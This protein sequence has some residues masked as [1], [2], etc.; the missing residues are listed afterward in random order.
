[1]SFRRA[2]GASASRLLLFQQPA[3]PAPSLSPFFAPLLLQTQPEMPKRFALSSFA[4][5]LTRHPCAKS[6]HCHFYATM[7]GGGLT[8]LQTIPSQNESE[9]SYVTSFLTPP[10]P[11]CTVRTL[12]SFPAVSN[13]KEVYMSFRKALWALGV[14]VCLA[15]PAV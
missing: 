13:A 4:A 7:S 9:C 1:M 5:T 15:A 10:A 11:R 8:N 12:G 3:P 14:V 2:G 6:F